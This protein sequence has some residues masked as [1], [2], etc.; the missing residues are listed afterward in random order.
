MS[1]KT[2]IDRIQDEVTAQ[3]DLLD[4][5]VTALEGKAAGSGGA[6]VQT[7]TVNVSADGAGGGL[8]KIH[9]CYV[10]D[11]GET[12]YGTQS[13]DYSISETIQ[14]C[15]CNS[16]FMAEYKQISTAGLTVENGEMLYGT[17]GY[18]VAIVLTAS[19]GGTVTL[20]NNYSGTT[21]WEPE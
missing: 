16:I 14:N 11:A 19:A 21:D 20:N 3:S 17:I 2:Q 1:V 12:Q 6:S 9:Y 13:F 15:V 10:D 4:Q 18:S 7:C 5:I 8:T